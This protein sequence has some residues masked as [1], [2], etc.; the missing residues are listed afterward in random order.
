MYNLVDLELFAQYT[1]C[2]DTSILLM[3]LVEFKVWDD[4]T[5]LWE[6]DTLSVQVDRDDLL[7]AEGVEVVIPDEGENRFCR[8]MSKSGIIGLFNKID[9]KPNRLYQGFIL[10]VIIVIDI[11][12]I[13]G[14]IV[15]MKMDKSK[16][17]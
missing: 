17:V 2:F 13:V 3:D 7:I 11:L 4:T 10:Y 15:G 1:I 5:S 14:V 8:R 6:F 12:L 16:T 9:E